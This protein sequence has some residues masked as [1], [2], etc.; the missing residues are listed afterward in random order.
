MKELEALEST[1]KAARIVSETKYETP[2]KR[3]EA[4]GAVSTVLNARLRYWH[5]AETHA[6]YEEHKDD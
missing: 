4:I 6:A 1:I 5:E 2:D 3:V